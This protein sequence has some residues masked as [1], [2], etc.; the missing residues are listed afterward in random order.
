MELLIK[1]I[2]KLG[3]NGDAWVDEHSGEVIRYIDFDVSDGFKEGFKD[4]SRSIMEQDANDISIEQ[5]KDR[6]NKKEV[7]LSPEGQIVSNIIV[8]ITSNM[9]INLDK[10]HDYII[11]VVTEL[12]SDVKVI[13]KEAAYREREKEAAKKG[14]KIPEYMLVYSSTLLYLSLGMILVAIQT[15]IPSIKTRKTFPGCVRSFNGF[16]LEG[17]GDDSGLNYLSC[18]AYKYKNPQVLVPQNAHTN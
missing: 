17:E 12:M 4:V 2:G 13:E 7:R 15:S 5:H 8:S 18:I 9:G 11:K 16:P 3:D 14:K 10:S 6:K 1:E